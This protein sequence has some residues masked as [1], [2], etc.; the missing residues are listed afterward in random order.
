MQRSIV[1]LSSTCD[2]FS[3]TISIKKTEVLHQTAPNTKQ[4]KAAIK[5]K[6]QCLQTVDSFTYLGSTLSSNVVIDKEID[7]RIAKASVA[8]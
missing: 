2:A 3:L 5:V 4:E 8:F 7:T 6:S 1:K